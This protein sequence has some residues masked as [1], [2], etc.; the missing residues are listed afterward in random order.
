[1]EETVEKIIALLGAENADHR[2]QGIVLAARMKCDSAVALL[3]EIAGSDPDQ[4]LRILARKAL[5]HLGQTLSAQPP[6]DDSQKYADKH[7]EQLLHSEDPYAR[8]AG[9][10]KALLQNDDIARLCILSALEKE[11]ERRDLYTL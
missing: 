8:F 6:S 5:E 11:S 9:L 7:F 4:E 1:M 10:K 3:T 2:R